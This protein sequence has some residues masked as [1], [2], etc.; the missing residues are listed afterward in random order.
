VQNRGGDSGDRRSQRNEKLARYTN[1]H[2]GDGSFT[3][4]QNTREADIYLASIDSRETVT[5]S[6][7]PWNS[8]TAVNP[9]GFPSKTD[10]M[11][12]A[13]PFASV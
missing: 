12:V 3:S 5:Y 4:T 6:L 1:R 7:F 8:K 10:D 2:S 9:C 11:T 13:R